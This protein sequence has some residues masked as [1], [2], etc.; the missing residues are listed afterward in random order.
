LK[1]RL[2]FIS[3]SSSSSFVVLGFSFKDDLLEDIEEYEE[4]LEEQEAYGYITVLRGSD[5]G[6]P[7]G[8]TVLGFDLYEFDDCGQMSSANYSLHNITEK[9]IDLRSKIKN[10]LEIEDADFQEPAIFGGTRCC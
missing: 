8:E 3:N 7:D 9:L 10:T 4:I 1:T 2:G 5:D 6:I